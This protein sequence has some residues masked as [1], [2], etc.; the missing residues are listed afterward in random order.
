M[1]VL[2]RAPG[3]MHVVRQECGFLLGALEP[4]QYSIVGL[5][6]SVKCTGTSACN[7]HK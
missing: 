2:F 5:R 3:Q 6:L 1:A 4:E 7:P